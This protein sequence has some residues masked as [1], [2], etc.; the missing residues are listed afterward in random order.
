MLNKLNNCISQGARCGCQNKISKIYGKQQPEEIC[1]Q[2]KTA[3]DQAKREKWYLKPKGRKGIRS[4]S[5]RTKKR[6]INTSVFEVTK[7]T[8]ILVVETF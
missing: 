2:Q 3:E 8:F 1:P 5:N 6:E 7:R 4:D